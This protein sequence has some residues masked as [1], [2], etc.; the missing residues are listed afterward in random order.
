MDI[1]KED[2]II[3]LVDF[4]YPLIHN[5]PTKNTITKI[6]IS[7][8]CMGANILRTGVIVVNIFKYPVNG[9]ANTA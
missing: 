6:T 3:F 5:T 2:I 9:F 1:V 7:E 4:K 8:R